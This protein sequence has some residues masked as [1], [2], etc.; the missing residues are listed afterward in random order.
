MASS[1]S[2]DPTRRAVAPL[3]P[4]VILPGEGDAIR[5]PVGGPTTYKARAETT[6]GTFTAMENVL[7]P[8]QGPPLHLHVREDEMWYV[9]EGE[10]R[11]KADDRIFAAPTGSFM[12][13]PRG[14]PHCLQNISDSIPAKVLVMFTPAGMERFFDGIG[15]LPAGPVDPDVYG[16]IA[17]S[18]WMKVVGPPVAESDPL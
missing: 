18:A 6:N 5:G 14:T 11:F 12:F 16:A 1:V 13:I 10:V 2:P 7:A 17:H 8:L 15:E 3:R 9:L 4:F